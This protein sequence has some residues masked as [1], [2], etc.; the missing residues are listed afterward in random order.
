MIPERK[1]R[2]DPVTGKKVYVDTGRM[3]PATVRSRRLAETEDAFT[4]SSGT[5]MEA[6]YA[7]H[8]NKLK[9][10]ANTARK[11]AVNTKN[12]P[13]SPSAK[14]AYSNE[15]AS[16]NAKLN[17]AEKNAPL[18]R[19]AQ[20]LANTWT[21]QKR[22][23]N[24]NM[25]AEEVKKIKQQHLNEAR[26][27]TGAGKERIKVTQSEWDAIQA[28]AISTN[29]LEK[30]I[31]NADG[32]TIK[33]LALPKESTRMTG[34]MLRRA[35]SMLDSGYTQAE[36]ADHLGIGLTTLKVGLSE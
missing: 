12:T 9:A 15:V 13:Y 22:Q 6:V 25:E 5:K 16:L 18:E 3:V 36:V 30:I 35:Q 26:N 24:P 32:D 19:Q 31:S 1:L 2:R 7:E 4:L 21:S 34:T 11:D 10:L 28:G 14:A 33:A 23:A 8:S 17:I 20:L 27:R 29:K